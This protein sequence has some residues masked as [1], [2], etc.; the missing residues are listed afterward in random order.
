VSLRAELGADLPHASALAPEFYGALGYRLSFGR[1]LSSGLRG[2]EELI[3]IRVSSKVPDDGLHRAHMQAEAV[4]N[5]RSGESV[6]EVSTADLET[7]V[8]RAGRLFK[9]LCQYLGASHAQLSVI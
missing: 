6:K 5:G 3:E 1:S 4:R 8:N 2:P 7:T 9:N